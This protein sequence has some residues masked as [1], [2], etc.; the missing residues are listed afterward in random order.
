VNI[1]SAT[2]ALGA[3]AQPRRLHLFRYLVAAG[4]AG[5]TPKELLGASKVANATLSFHL[6]ELMD[7]KLIIQ[8]RQGRHRIYR[9][10]FDEIS[11]LL[12]YLAEDCCQGQSCAVNLKLKV[13]K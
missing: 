13:G 7:A 1:K 11:A 3:L 9:A 12:A 10:C 2:R 5:A 8:E 4:S 6:K